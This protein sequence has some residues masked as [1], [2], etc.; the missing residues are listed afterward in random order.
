MADIGGKSRCKSHPTEIAHDDI[1]KKAFMRP[2]LSFVVPYGIFHLVAYIFNMRFVRFVTAGRRLYHDVKCRD[3]LAITNLLNEF[4]FCIDHNQSNKFA[5]LFAENGS[6]K[7]E[8]I[9]AYFASPS[10]LEDLCCQLHHRFTPA[11]HFVS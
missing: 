11:L 3:Q 10:E 7:I 4:L 9:G 2:R 1:Q 8:K 5:E 6:C